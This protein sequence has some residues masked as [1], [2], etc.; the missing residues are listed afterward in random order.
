MVKNW[1]NFGP[2][3]AVCYKQAGIANSLV[4]MHEPSRVAAPAR[5]YLAVR[6]RNAPARSGAFSSLS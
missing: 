3:M 4:T 6:T 1:H 5:D 2:A